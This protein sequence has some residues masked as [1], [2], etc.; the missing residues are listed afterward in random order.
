M[1]EQADLAETVG[2]NMVK[3]GTYDV[4]VTVFK[5]ADGHDYCLA[6][7]AGYGHDCMSMVHAVGCRKCASVLRPA[8]Q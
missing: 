6:I 1:A 2:V 5:A 4:T 8:E 3:C 7:E